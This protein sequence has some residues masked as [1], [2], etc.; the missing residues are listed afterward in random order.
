MIVSKK[1]IIS[2]SSRDARKFFLKGDS[3]CTIILPPYFKFEPILNSLDSEIKTKSIKDIV[4]GSKLN[5]IK[6]VNNVN[7]N[8]ISNKDGMLS[9]RQLQIINPAVY[10]VLC[11]LIT[12]DKNWE[13]IKNRFRKFQKYN[14]IIEATGIPVVDIKN[15]KHDATQINEWWS[16]NEQKAIELSLE[17]EYVAHT[18]ISTFYDSIY[19]HSIVWA[20]HGKKDTKKLKFNIKSKQKLNKLGDE[21]DTI[22][23]SMSY[24]ETH[25][26]PQGNIISD[27]IAEILLGY[28]DVC[29]FYS[30]RKKH[31]DYKILRYRDDYRIFTH[32]PVDAELILAEISKTLHSVGLRLNSKKTLISNDVI[33]TSVKKDKLDNLL[34]IDFNNNYIPKL[35]LYIYK[36][37]LA[38]SNSGTI[39]KFLNIL[40]DVVLDKRSRIKN[41]DIVIISLLINIA[42]KNPIVYPRVA[43]IISLIIAEKDESYKKSLAEKILKRFENIP[44]ISWLEVWLQRIFIKSPSISTIIAKTPICKCALDNKVRIWNSDWLLSKYKKIMDKIG[45][46]DESTLKGSDNIIHKTEFDVFT[47]Y[48]IYR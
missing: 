39:N 2:L 1:N 46:I 9:W 40:Y 31:I 27:L 41:N 37:S 29:I 33:S 30:L 23:Q 35:L 24:G 7:Y 34:N 21:I 20:L 6:S 43:G 11:N 10:L 17:F 14:H 28:L 12:D 13:Y 38:H 26:I 36:T 44:Y 47:D 16:R 8:F 3:Y 22:F 25:G 5:N 19:T 42:L 15:K 18:D 45:I 4:N 32:S 48:E